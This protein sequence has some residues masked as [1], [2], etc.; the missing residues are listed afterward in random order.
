MH[1]NKVGR[2]VYYEE[3]EEYTISEAGY[4]EDLL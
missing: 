4:C 1:P 3:V 2:I